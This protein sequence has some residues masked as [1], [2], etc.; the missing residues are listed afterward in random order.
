ASVGI[1]HFPAH[2]DDV[3]TLMQ[4][5]D[6]AMYSAKASGA[7]VEVYSASRDGH[8]R[9]RLALL[10]ELPEAIECGE[11]VVHYQPQYDLATGALVGAEALAR[12]QHPQHGLLG[13]G[14]FLSLAE[15]TGLMRPLTLRVL[16]DALARCAR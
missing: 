15:Q 14:A 12:W 9:E 7:G 1:A 4:R 3:E 16:A 6:I 8:S 10:G 2:G 5:A 11:I 13:P